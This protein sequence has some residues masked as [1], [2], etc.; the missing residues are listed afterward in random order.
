MKRLKKIGLGILCS[1]AL[2]TAAGCSAEDFNW[3]AGEPKSDTQSQVIKAEFEDI[4]LKF[5]TIKLGTEAQEFKGGTSLEAVKELYGEPKEHSQQKAGD[6]TLEVYKWEF[7]HIVVEVQ[8][9]ENSAIVR[10]LSN[11]AFIREKTVDKAVYDSI[12]NG[13]SFTKAKEVLGE[14]DVL[15]EAVSTGKVELQA[16]WTSN[17]KS[18]QTN[19]ALEL[20]FENDKIVRKNQIAIK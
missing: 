3:S 11:F 17:L 14:P 1:L 4:R 12:E 10:S 2:V 15:S 6:V 7:K 20:V 18:D 13:W 19:P 8:F 16:V 5:N 9:Y